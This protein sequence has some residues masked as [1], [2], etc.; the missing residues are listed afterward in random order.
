LCPFYAYTGHVDDGV[1]DG[2]DDG[3]YDGA[4]DF[5]KNLNFPSPYLK[6][7]TNHQTKHTGTALYN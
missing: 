4:D 7:E 1:P 3:A 5:G 2:V 6:K